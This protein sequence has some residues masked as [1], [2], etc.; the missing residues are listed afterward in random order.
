M[1]ITALGVNSAFATGGYRDVI[2]LDRL[3]TCLI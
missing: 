3:I 1:K 2:D